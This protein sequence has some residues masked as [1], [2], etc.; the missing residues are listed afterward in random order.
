MNESTSILVVD[1]HPDILQATVRLLRGAGFE[2]SGA[3]TGN[4]VLSLLREAPFDLVLLEVV[5]P[6]MDGREI[7]RRIKSD[8]AMQGTLVMM[9]SV[10]RTSSDQQ[11]DGLDLGADGYIVRPV[12]NRELLAR[13][14]SLARIQRAEGALRRIHERLETLVEART[15]ELAAAN[16]SLL[17]EVEVRRST[18]RELKEALEEIER[19]KDRLEKENLYL[20]EEIR[21]TQH[22]EDI[23]G[24]SDALKYVLFR[25]EQVAPTD[26]TVLILGETGTGKE[27]IARALHQASPRK[28]RLMVKVN[29]AALAPNL[30]ESELFGHQKGAF[31]GAGT[32]QQGRFEVADGTT[33]FLDEI[34]DLP[35]ELQAKLLRV[36][37]DGE[38]ERLGSSRTI[39]VDVR[40]VA[41]TNRNLKEEV[42]RGR[43]REDLWYRLNM[44]PITVPPLR[45][46]REDIPLL[47]NVFAT[48]FAKKL[49]R[50]VCRIE[51][52]AL[53]AMTGYRWP[54]NIRELENVIERA[55]IIS[56]GPDLVVELPAM[57]DQVKDDSRTLEEV[58][59]RHILRV[60]EESAWKIEGRGGAARVLKLNPGTLRSRM[61][62]LGIER[63]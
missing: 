45:Q 8:P 47:A 16:V 33:L 62:K 51:P 48:R 15:A 6:D 25:V 59:R 21:L 39:R 35:L 36:L 52:A 50:Q 42:T 22:F 7:C 63:P 32:Q 54:G 31:T 46:R 28:D 40:V 30:I 18:E 56:Q 11:A 29:C 24:Q 12:S 60:L 53:E 26:A 14:H 55:V 43:F 58:E 27:L 13:V 37:Q 44:F 34:G 41:A 9:L 4:E 10:S 57:T 3:S 61:K 23:V 2:V 5:L 17:Q 49:G 19:M 38:F 20:Q 1:E